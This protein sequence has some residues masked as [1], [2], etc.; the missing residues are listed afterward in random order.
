MSGLFQGDVLI[1]EAIQL[2]IDD[3]R[4]N[5]WLIDH[6]LGD[7]TSISYLKKKYGQKQID[8]CKEWFR[9]Q[10]IDVYNRDRTDKDRLPCVTI[11]TGSDQE[12]DDMKHM[13]DQST[14]SVI[15]MPQEIGKPIPYV[16]KPF[17][18]TGYDKNTGEISI[19]N[20][21]DWTGIAPNM[22]LVNPDNGQGYVILEVTP[23][24]V[25]IEP[26]MDLE[27]TQ[28]AVVPK[29]QIYKA[30]VEH[31][32]FNDTYTIS[33][34]AHGDHQNVLWLHSIVLYS[35]LR[36]REALLEANGFAES[37]V[38]NSP[39]V[40]T[41]GYTGPG[42]EMAWTRSIQL[43][44]QTEASWI[45]SPR[46]YIESVV[47]KDQIDATHYVGGIKICSNLDT[48][49]IIDQSQNVWNTTDGDDSNDD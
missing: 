25:L 3:M 1:Y 17:V 29:F 38:S 26:D 36:Y 27:A 32:F 46:R 37:K 7:F 23:N 21:V 5:D 43:T 9:N 33:C 41:D 11:T 24:G 28:L 48:P 30:R 16:V 4:K 35:I 2:G 20:T 8:A 6:M 12:K 47:L 22:I 39:I 15:L 14:E 13:G 40:L 45:K 44:G 31:T 34:H 49:D 10:Q 42:G 19:P 18:P